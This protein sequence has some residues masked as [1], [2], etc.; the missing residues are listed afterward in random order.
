MSEIL[1]S[2]ACVTIVE[3]VVAPLAMVGSVLIHG[4]KA[5]NEFTG[6]GVEVG[7]QGLGGG[8]VASNVT[9]ES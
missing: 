2:V 7:R 3:V 6:G 9:R 5:R 4:R 8:D 1:V